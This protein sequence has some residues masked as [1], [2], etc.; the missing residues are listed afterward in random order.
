[1]RKFRPGQRVL[2]T[3]LRPSDGIPMRYVGITVTILS[4]D[5]DRHEE[6]PY[7]VVEDGRWVWRED[8]FTDAGKSTDPNIIFKLNKSAKSIT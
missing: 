3:Q 7:R 5:P 6:W 2:V 8:H 4:S 1:M